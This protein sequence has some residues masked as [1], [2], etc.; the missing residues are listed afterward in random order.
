MLIERAGSDARADTTFGYRR[1]A[2]ILANEGSV[3]AAVRRTGPIQTPF[4]LRSLQDGS[5]PLVWYSMITIEAESDAETALVDRAKLMLK[6]ATDP[7]AKLLLEMLT[8][9]SLGVEDDKIPYVQRLA[10][11]LE[12]LPNI[13]RRSHTYLKALDM[14]AGVHLADCDG[15]RAADWFRRELDMR[16]EGPGDAHWLRPPE[17]F[18]AYHL[19]VFTGEMANERLN[20]DADGIKIVR[21]LAVDETGECGFDGFDFRPAFKSIARQFPAL[22]TRKGWLEGTM[23]DKLSREWLEESLGKNWRY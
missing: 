1:P 6:Q 12:R 9:S 23:F 22:A 21:A 20:P 3:A 13:V 10:S 17:K 14:I 5:D 8:I 15:E 2:A 7:E 19:F 11:Q 4:Y 16:V 18:L